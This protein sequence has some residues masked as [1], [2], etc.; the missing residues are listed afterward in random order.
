MQNKELDH[1]YL[2]DTNQAAQL[3]AA[4]PAFEEPHLPEPNRP[5]GPRD[6]KFRSLMGILAGMLIGILIC[7]S[8]FRVMT[9]QSEGAVKDMDY[10]TKVDL[11]I[12]YLSLYYLNDLDDQMIEDALAKGLM[13]NIGD[14]YA[15]YYTE[16]EFQ[17]FMESMN[18]EYA[19]IGVMITQ[20]EED[21]AIEVYKVYSG[22]PAEQAGIQMKDLIVEAAGLRNFETLDDLVAVVR[23]EPGTTVDLVVDRNGEEIPMTIERNRIEIDYVYGEMLSDRV[24]YMQIEEFTTATAQQFNDT[25]DALA[26][27]GM[28]SLII[29]LRN[30]PGGDYD[31][32]VAMCD[33]VVPEGV[34]VSVEDNI[35]GMQTENS[36]AV[37]L[38]IPIVLLVN[39]NT[40]SAAELFTMCLRDYDM[41]TVVGMTTFGKG[42]VQSIFQLPDGSGLKFTTEKY[43]GPKGG[44]IQ[45]TGITP[46]YELDFTEEAYEDG[47]ITVDEDV[48]LQKA[49]ELLG[50]TMVYNEE[51]GEYEFVEDAAGSDVLYED[52]A[53]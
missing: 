12:Q 19:G 52:T 42:I 38:D 2:E 51:T 22:S 8:V 47:L 10:G 37:C 29:D 35:G 3:Q 25:L 48:Q 20:R 34:I 39:N 18:G 26:T 45:E 1:L 24:G 27:E 53:A 14:P 36:D 43:Y 9:I 6:R 31:A 15:Q 21:K 17:S 30:N 28:T 32:V 40:A 33:R 41:A 50:L 13:A 5:R 49:A 4:D 7:A 46:D 16:E 23:G 11:I 44:Y